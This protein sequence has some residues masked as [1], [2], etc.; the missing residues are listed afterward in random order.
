MRRLNEELDQAICRCTEKKTFFWNYQRNFFPKIWRQDTQNTQNKPRHLLEIK[1]KIA[2][3]SHTP[4][5]QN[6][7]VIPLTKFQSLRYPTG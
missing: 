6:P 1:I 3:L 4:K 7:S 5:D 2:D